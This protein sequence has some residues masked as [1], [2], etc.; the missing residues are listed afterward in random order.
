[1]KW[2]LIAVGVVAGLVAAVAIVG[3]LLPR[4]HVATVQA[5]IAAPPSSVWTAIADPAGYP[6]WRPDVTKIDVLPATV[7]GPSWR[8]HSR[9][10]SITMVVD[11]ADA[12]RRMVGR[13]AD[14]GLPY[15]GKWIYEIE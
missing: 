11:E 8:E 5:R 9:H 13:I 7:T 15:G 12:P 1:M 4:D 10:G 6:A 3:M 2:A 14:E